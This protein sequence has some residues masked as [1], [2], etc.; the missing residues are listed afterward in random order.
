MSFFGLRAWST[1]V[2]RP[3]F[4]FF[5]GGVITFFLV[6]KLQNAMIQA[7]EYANDPRNPLAKA[8]QQNAH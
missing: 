8:K 7:P 1:P 3:M 5:A 6:A 4:P 2:F